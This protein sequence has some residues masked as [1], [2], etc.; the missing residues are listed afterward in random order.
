MLPGQTEPIDV[1]GAV[2]GVRPVFLAHG[3]LQVE[4]RDRIFLIVQIHVDGDRHA[5]FPQPVDADSAHRAAGKIKRC[6]QTDPAALQNTGFA[7][8]QKTFSVFRLRERH[9]IDHLIGIVSRRH[10]LHAFRQHDG[11]LVVGVRQFEGS[12]GILHSQ[13]P[14]C[15]FFCLLSGSRVRRRI[16]AIRCKSNLRNDHCKRQDKR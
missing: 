9:L 13:F 12:V 3:A 1:L 10:R 4:R 6:V 16:I 15:R 7:G 2:A 8:E 14:A 5:S 11:S